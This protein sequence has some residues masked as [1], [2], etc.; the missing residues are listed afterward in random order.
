MLYKFIVWACWT[1]IHSRFGVQAKTG[2]YIGVWLSF[3]LILF[4]GEIIY[5]K[6]KLTDSLKDISLGKLFMEKKNNL[7]F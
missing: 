6:E 1:W 5:L 4:L 7:F 2:P 3:D